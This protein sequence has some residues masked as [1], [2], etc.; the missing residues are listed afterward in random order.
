MKGS[1]PLSLAAT[2]RLAD[3]LID[4][5]GAQPVTA[6]RVLPPLL[7]ALIMAL[8]W[9][10]VSHSGLIFNLTP[11]LPVGIYQRIPLPAHL[12]PGDLVQI[13]PPSPASSPAMRQ[14]IHDH[15]LLTDRRSVCLD[16]LVPFDKHI[17]AVPRQTVS[18]S[19]GGLVVN[20]HLLP[21]TQIQRISKTGGRIIHYPLGNYTVRPG[22]IWVTDN[23]S[24]WAYDSRY[25]GPISVKNLISG[26]E[27][28]M[29]W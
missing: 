29:T 1:D 5:A 23:S 16:H 6:A 26:I 17:A 22:T 4:E 20:G 24:P 8:G 12:K 11:S 21:R 25:Y 28:V 7:A 10:R 13:C 9:S 15:W 3:F 2:A 27:P 14:A 19:T 18:L